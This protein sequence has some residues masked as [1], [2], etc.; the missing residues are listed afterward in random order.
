MN[1]LIVTQYYWP[2]N[3]SINGIA[4]SL[5]EKG[6]KVEIL[7]GKPNYPHGRVFDGYSAFGM[8]REHHEGILLHRIPIFPRFASPLGLALNYISFVFS[9]LFFGPIL[10]RQKKYDVIFVY[11]PSPILQAI[12]ALLIGWMKRTPV[13][14][15]VQDLWPESLSATGYVKNKHI[16]NLI[17]KIVQFIYGN[18]QL[19]LVQS[20]AFLS[21]VIALSSGVQVEYLPNSY[22]PSTLLRHAENLHDIDVFK[23]GFTIL[24]TGNVGSA[25]SI[26]V[27]I[28]AATILSSH[29][30]IHFIVVGDGSKK[31]WMIN[32]AQCRNLRNL[33]MVG[34]F[35]ASYMPTFMGKA[36]VLLATLS[37]QPIFALT[38]PNKIQAYMSSGRPIIACMDGEGAR[39]VTESGAGF[40][41]PAQ[42]PILL[43]E[44]VLKLYQMSSQERDNMGENGRTYFKKY[45]DHDILVNRLMDILHR[46]ANKYK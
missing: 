34:Q 17:K 25:Q 45:F 7:T 4:K 26:E 43:S 1:V 13:V 6:A 28:E 18:V 10:L 14:L 37:R 36:S 38:V 15:W 2:E 24:F 3:F 29:D 40:A 44:A 22:K 16:I 41:V 46:E 23:L 5:V 21:P 35:P 20:E 9:G 12:P 30:D 32:E 8:D 27:I 42:D 31:N 19:I 33:H 11:A 39:L